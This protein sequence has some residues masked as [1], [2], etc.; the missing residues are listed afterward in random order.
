MKHIAL[1][2][3]LAMLSL[4]ACEKKHSEEP[5][6]PTPVFSDRAFLPAGHPPV[7]S[8]DQQ[9]S[10]APEVVQMENAT[11]VSSIDIPQFTYIEVKQNNQTRWIAA[12]TIA[13]KRGDV[14]QFD[15]GATIIGFNSKALGRDFPNMT[16]VNHVSIDKGK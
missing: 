13:V 7:N 4:V 16:F 11:V 5:F 1:I 3:A 15:N 8:N 14:I 10:I 9:N 6:V 12:S 2:S